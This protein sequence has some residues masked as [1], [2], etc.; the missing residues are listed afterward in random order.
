MKKLS[1]FYSLKTLL[2]FLKIT[3]RIFCVNLNACRYRAAVDTCTCMEAH[4]TF[5]MTL[6][7]YAGSTQSSG[8]FEVVQQDVRVTR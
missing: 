5:H 2:K 1:D 6:V 4:G 7:E 8:A 3:T